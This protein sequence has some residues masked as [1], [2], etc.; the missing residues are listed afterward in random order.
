MKC[1]FNVG[2]EFKSKESLNVYN[3]FV[4]SFENHVFQT[5]SMGKWKDKFYHKCEMP[6]F[7]ACMKT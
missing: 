3:V 6:S 2:N 1:K 5:F 4:K 7:L